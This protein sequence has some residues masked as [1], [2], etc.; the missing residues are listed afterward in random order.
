MSNT[1]KT[2][3]TEETNRLLDALQNVGGTPKQVRRGIRNHCLAVV[4]L[5]AGLRVSETIGLEV[6]DLIFNNPDLC[7]A[8]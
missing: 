1:P 4:M 5:D 7:K 8:L 2:L 3:T 6:R